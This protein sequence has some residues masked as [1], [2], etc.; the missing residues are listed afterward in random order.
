[1]KNVVHIGSVI[2]GLLKTYRQESD[3]ELAQI[4]DLW[5]K[6]VGDAIAENARPSAFKGKLL[7]VQ[8]TNSSWLHQLHFLKKDIIQKINDTYGKELVEEIKFKI[9]SI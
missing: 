3:A 8:V 2:D 9:G 1:M 4:W 5:D 7:L 6:L